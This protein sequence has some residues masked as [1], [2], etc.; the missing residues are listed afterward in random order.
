M[1]SMLKLNLV[2]GT[3]HS[4]SPSVKTPTSF[5]VYKNVRQEVM[6]V[7]QF[8]EYDIDSRATRLIVAE[9]LTSAEESSTVLQVGLL[10]R[11]LHRYTVRLAQSR[12]VL[13]Q[14]QQSMPSIFYKHDPVF[15]IL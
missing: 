4:I 3:R 6:T 10:E 7:R 5:T 12:S 9:P 14:L 8:E 11:S 15:V 13:I 2:K 1:N